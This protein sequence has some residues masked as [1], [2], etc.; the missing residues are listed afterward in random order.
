MGARFYSEFVYMIDKDNHPHFVQN[1]YGANLCDS[2]RSNI[3]LENKSYC[4][5]DLYLTDEVETEGEFLPRV[6][7]TEWRDF[8][9]EGPSPDVSTILEEAGLADVAVSKLVFVWMSSSSHCI[10]DLGGFVSSTGGVQDFDEDFWKQALSHARAQ[11][12][13]AAEQEFAIADWVVEQVQKGTFT[14]V[15]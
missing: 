4:V 8:W 5:L 10:L 15:K 2:Y 11:T 9:Q 12:G 1:Y 13:S 14:A 6:K 3:Y 7:E